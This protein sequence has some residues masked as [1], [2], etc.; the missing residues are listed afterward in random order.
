[1]KGYYNQSYAKNQLDLDERG[2]TFDKICDVWQEKKSR[3]SILDIG[4]GA[5]SVSEEL[6][7]RGHTVH[8][9]DIIEE[10][11][12]RAKKRGL[13]AEVYDLNQVPLPFE[14]GSFDCVLALDVLEHIF[15]PMAL[16]KE[17]KRLLRVSGYAIIFLPLHFD[18]RQRL[19]M[20]VGK[21]L[22]QYEH[23][24][25]DPNCVA[26]EYFHIRFFTLYEAEAFITA[27]GFFIERRVYRPIVT[28]NI[29]WPGK[30]LL[31]IRTARFLAPR[32]PSLFAS[33]VKMV[34]SSFSPRPSVL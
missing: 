28:A 21:G 24:M 13:I 19:R 9:I 20:L 25:Y 3:M 29:G 5:G 22:I 18:L 30:L 11:V 4:C 23:L 6:V 33:G 26:W 12:S 14:D 1:M 27:G 7:R 15:D 2:N 10:G 16:L 32:L 34:I 31:N 17:I 8:G